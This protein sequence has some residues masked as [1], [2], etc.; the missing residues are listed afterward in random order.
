MGADV[1]TPA[2]KVKAEDAHRLQ[3][4]LALLRD[5]ERPLRGDQGSRR[6]LV[7]RLPQQG[8]Q[9]GL[10]VGKQAVQP[11]AGHIRLENIKQRV[12]A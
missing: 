12:I 9:P 10:E 5:R 3:T 8:R 6:L 11:G 2:V 7:D 4:Q 1:Q